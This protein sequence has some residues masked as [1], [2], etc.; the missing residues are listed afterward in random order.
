MHPRPDFR[1]KDEQDMRAFVA[2]RGFAHIFAQTIEGPM[3]VHAPVT[4]MADGALRFHVGRANRI[5][6][7]LDGAAVVASIAADDSYISPDW[8]DGPD[9]VPTW[10]FRAVEV[11]GVA[12]VLDEAALV[13]QLDALSAAFEAGLAPKRPWTRA[14]MA[15]G[16]FEGMLPGILAFEI[17]D[18][19]W[20]GTAKMSQ[21][22]TEADRRGVIDGL[23]GIGRGDVAAHIVP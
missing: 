13:A 19:I 17:A 6:R 9:Q 2:S 11:A 16:T 20:R 1:W 4:V 10:N 22:K 8:Y 12:R 14:K 7:H 3:V 15:P 23:R 18:T 5:R 21:N